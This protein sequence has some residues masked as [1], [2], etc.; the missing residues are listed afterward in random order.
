[1]IEHHVHQNADAAP[2]RLRHETLEVVVGAVVRLDPVV[3][4][5]IVAVIAGRCGH[6]HEPDAGRAEVRVDARVAVVD[7]VELLDQAAQVADAVAV[8]VVEGA[9]EDLVAGPPRVHAGPWRRSRD[10]CPWHA[11]VGSGP[12]MRPARQDNEPASGHVRIS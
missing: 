1:M 10:A 8:A 9:N 5:D 6:R 7:V 11:R 12:R 3:V 2:M 4:A